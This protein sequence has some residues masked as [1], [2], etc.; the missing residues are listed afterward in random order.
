MEEEIEIAEIRVKN[1]LL[2][3]KQTTF[4]ILKNIFILHFQFHI[5][6]SHINFFLFAYI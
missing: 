1:T 6:F 3:Q 2:R 5:K 4:L